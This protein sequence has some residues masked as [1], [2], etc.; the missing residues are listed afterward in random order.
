MP[1]RV[2]GCILSNVSTPSTTPVIGQP[3]NKTPPICQNHTNSNHKP[4]ACESN[5]SFCPQT[6]EFYFSS[7]ETHS[8]NNSDD[9][10]IRYYPDQWSGDNI[11]IKYDS[12]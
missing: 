9:V 6:S 3:Q 8:D 4:T 5:S 10:M 11:I 12:E 1:Q 2:T 7:E